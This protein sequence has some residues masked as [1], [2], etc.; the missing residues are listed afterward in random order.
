MMERKLKIIIIILVILMVL[1]GVGGTALYL[2]TDFFIFVEV[3][4]QKYI[5]QNV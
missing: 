4:F 3:L 2:T 5:A 1:I